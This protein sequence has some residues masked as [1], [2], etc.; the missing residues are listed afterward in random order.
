MARQRDLGYRDKAVMVRLIE[1]LQFDIKT[2]LPQGALC[3][4]VMQCVYLNT[5]HNADY[6]L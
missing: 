6:E 4:E 3:C 5:S 1:C 2:F